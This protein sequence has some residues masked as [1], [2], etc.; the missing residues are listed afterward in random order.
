LSAPFSIDDMGF[1]T[2]VSTVNI[3]HVFGD[4]VPAWVKT[5]RLN[6]TRS[7]SRQF[8]GVKEW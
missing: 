3:K 4:A 1:V 8:V 5:A 6:N 7:A 2:T